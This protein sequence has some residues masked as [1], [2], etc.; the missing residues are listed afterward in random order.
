MH[1]RG[2]KADRIG[3]VREAAAWY[4]TVTANESVEANRVALAHASERR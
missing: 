2:G 1:V 3:K 4:L